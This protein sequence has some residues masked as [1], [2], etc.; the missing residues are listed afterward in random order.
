MRTNKKSEEN[1][2]STIIEKGTLSDRLSAVQLKFQK[3]PI[4][5]LDY[6]ERFVAMLEKRKMRDAINLLSKFCDFEQ[7][8][9]FI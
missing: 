4:H 7:K 3:T 8:I 6:L 5:S 2:L 1:W 9:S